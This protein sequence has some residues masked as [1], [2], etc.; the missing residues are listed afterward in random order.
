VCGKKKILCEI[1]RCRKNQ[2][3]S[4]KAQN[5]ALQ[6][7]FVRLQ[8]LFCHTFHFQNAS[9]NQ[10]AEIDLQ[11]SP[12]TSSSSPPSKTDTEQNNLES[13][14]VDYTNYILERLIEIFSG[15]MAFH[16]FSSGFVTF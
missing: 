12:N 4:S 13:Q 5:T 11:R 3:N 9:S 1:L 7:I 14:F 6:K 8:A 2:N 16:F 15:F 10:A